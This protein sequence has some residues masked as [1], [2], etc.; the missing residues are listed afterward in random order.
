MVWSGY[1]FPEDPPK[2]DPDDL[3]KDPIALVEFREWKTRRNFIDIEKAKASTLAVLLDFEISDC[4]KTS[5]RV[6]SSTS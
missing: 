2:I 4:F 6:N 1:K 5:R 3:Y